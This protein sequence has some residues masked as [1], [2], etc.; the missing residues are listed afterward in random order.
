MPEPSPDPLQPLIQRWLQSDDPDRVL[1]ELCREHPEHAVTLRERC[2][3]AGAK[4]DELAAPTEV[5]PYRIL[6]TLGQGGMGTVYLAEQREP[7]QRR[8]ALKLIKLGMDSKAIVQRFEQERQALAMMD[9]EG[10]AKV[11]DCGTSER[12]AGPCCEAC[13]ISMTARSETSDS[14]RKRGS[15]PTRC[16]ETTNDSLSAAV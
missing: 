2:G 16:T 15:L 8:V 14:L 3:R 11:Y 13:G 5:G 4:V 1:E 12:L 9:H 6:D 10:I 7:V